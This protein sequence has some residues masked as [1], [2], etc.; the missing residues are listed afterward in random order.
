[1]PLSLEQNT[2]T[3]AKSSKSAA[4]LNKY[5]T[6]AVHLT[7]SDTLFEANRYLSDFA[8]RPRWEEIKREDIDAKRQEIKKELKEYGFKDRAAYYGNIKAKVKK[9]MRE[10]DEE[11]WALGVPSN[12]CYRGN[13][14]RTAACR[15]RRGAG[16]YGVQSGGQ[17][18]RCADNAERIVFYAR[19]HRSETCADGVAQAVAP[20]G[21]ERIE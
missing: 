18:C 6:E 5:L 20:S 19:L 12:C 7:H 1:M 9:F 10:V 14:S 3:S 4:L 2:Q 13:I 16:V 8:T 17:S 11:L 21:K 15:R